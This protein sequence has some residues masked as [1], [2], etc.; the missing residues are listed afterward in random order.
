MAD[1]P[2]KVHLFKSGQSGNPSGRAPG[3]RNRLSHAFL[4]ALA[5][6]WEKHGEAVLRIMRIE[7][8]A[9]YVKTIAMLMP[10]ESH[11]RTDVGRLSDSELRELLRENRADETAR[12]PEQLN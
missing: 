3:S 6:D 9:D 12:N 7:K 11:V 4:T 5:D 2:S 1:H 10:S 8:P